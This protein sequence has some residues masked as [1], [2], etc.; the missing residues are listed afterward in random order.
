V[1]IKSILA[2]AF[3]VL[4]SATPS[5]AAGVVYSFTSDASMTFI[6]DT[7]PEQ[8][9]GTF[10][11]DTSGATPVLLSA[12]LTLSSSFFN[13]EDGTY[14]GDPSYISNNELFLNRVV[15]GAFD[16]RSLLIHFDN[17]FGALS[18]AIQ[19]ATWID[20]FITPP[21]FL[22]AGLFT[23][24]A[25]IAETPL[26]ATWTMMILGFAGIGFMAYRRKPKPAWMAA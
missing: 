16:H 15:N 26:P 20:P 22:P 24:S 7:G 17:P 18:L 21:E 23:G 11:V 6:L 1:G 19:S 9:S 10:T 12:S 25:Q 3:L 4:G 5:G 14:I 13:R 2:V 8:V